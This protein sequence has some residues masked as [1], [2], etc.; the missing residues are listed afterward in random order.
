MA[1]I[2]GT[3]GEGELP[4]HKT[5]LAACSRGKCSPIAKPFQLHPPQQLLFQTAIADP[6]RG[7]IVLHKC[8]MP[9]FL[10]IE[11]SVL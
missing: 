10:S 8:W 3:L 4:S 9:A 11:P 6:P 2:G 1:P 7:L 5:Q